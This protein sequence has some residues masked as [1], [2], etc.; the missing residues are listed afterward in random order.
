MLLHFGKIVVRLRE[1]DFSILRAST[2]VSRVRALRGWGA[3]RVGC[4][5]GKITFRVAAKPDDQLQKFQTDKKFAFVSKKLSMLLH[6]EKIVVRLRENDFS[7][8]RASTRVSRVRALHGWGAIRVG[9]YTGKI[10]FRVAAKPD[11]E[12]QKF[13]TDRKLAMGVRQLSMLLDF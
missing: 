11:D 1:N 9:C 3:I 12:L 5:T 10:T 4:Y 6:F 13:Q 7:I 2:R 8:L